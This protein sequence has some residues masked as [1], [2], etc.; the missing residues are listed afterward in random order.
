VRAIVALSF[1]LLVMPARADP[2]S[3]PYRL[4]WSFPNDE[5]SAI[6][7]DRGDLSASR[8]KSEYALVKYL[9]GLSIE[10]PKKPKSGEAGPPERE[11]RVEQVDGAGAVR[12][13]LRYVAPLEVWRKRV[14]EPMVERLEDEFDAHLRMV[15]P[16]KVQPVHTPGPPPEGPHGQL[17]RPSET[18]AALARQGPARSG[19]WRIGSR[20]GAASFLARAARR[21]PTI[22]GGRPPP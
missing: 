3:S 12:S 5:I 16:R 4:R 10:K 2:P 19:R 1:A 14:G 9:S 21:V 18:R 15:L 8:F 17:E 13:T 6:D 11:L 20:G 22:V 7:V